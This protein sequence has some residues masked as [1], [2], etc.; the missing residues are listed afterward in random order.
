M[1]IL[2]GCGFDLNMA[3]LLAH[4]WDN[5][6]IVPKAGR[7]LG[8]AFSTGRVVAQGYPASTMIFN[9]VVDAVVREV[10]AEV[11][12]TQDA[13]H[14]LVW[15]A[16]ELNLVFYADYGQIEGQDHVWVQDALAVT[17]AMSRR[18]GL[19]NN[20]EDTKS[21]VCTPGLIWGEW[22]K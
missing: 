10:L 21:M 8:K 16:G 3:L 12:G 11:F 6:Q 22:I 7:L 20:L 4:H 9:I 19:K 17:V 5:Q 13:H 14:G 18:V 2:Y 15:A 1:E